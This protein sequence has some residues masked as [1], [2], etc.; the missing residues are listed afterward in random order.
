MDVT[1]I[2]FHVF[3]IY[4]KINKIKFIEKIKKWIHLLKAIIINLTRMKK[5]NQNHG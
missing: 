1:M 2:V 5:S 4:K 3:L